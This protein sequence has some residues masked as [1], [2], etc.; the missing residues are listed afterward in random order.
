MN[1]FTVNKPTGKNGNLI[2]S[3]HLNQGGQIFIWGQGGVNWGF[4]QG[5]PD[6]AAQTQARNDPNNVDW[7][8]GNVD[9]STAQSSSR[10]ANVSGQTV[11]ATLNSTIINGQVTINLSAD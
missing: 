9:Y 1:S 8:F 7:N 5:L 10:D 11:V 3:F 2:T 4:S 6:L